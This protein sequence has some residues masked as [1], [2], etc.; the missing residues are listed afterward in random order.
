MEKGR[1]VSI[2]HGTMVFLQDDI[3]PAGCEN[4]G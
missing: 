2:W 3:E 4:P 1:V